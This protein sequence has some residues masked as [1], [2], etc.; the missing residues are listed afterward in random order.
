[1]RAAQWLISQNDLQIDNDCPT[2]E[3]GFG[4]VY[5]GMYL[6]EY[7][8]AIKQLLVGN[9]SKETES[10]LENEANTLAQLRSPHIVHY[11][12]ICMDRPYRLVMEYAPHGSLY[13]VL[14]SDEP[15]NWKTRYRYSL[16][17]A[18]G[19]NYLHRHRTIHR[20]LKSKNVLID[21]NYRAKITDFGLAKI[22]QETARV[23]SNIKVS[24]KG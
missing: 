12:G 19:V 8:V 6:Q 5:K 11:Y 16:D 2:K 17:I 15:L 24:L 20:D 10:E 3:G 21:E 1:M 22:K 4:R 14:H 23:F 13:D 18:M 9:F 7:A